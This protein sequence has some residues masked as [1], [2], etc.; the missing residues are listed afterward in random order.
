MTKAEWDQVNDLYIALLNKDNRTQFDEL[1]YRYLDKIITYVTVIREARNMGNK[2]PE[3]NF[4]IKNAKQQMDLAESKLRAYI[5]SRR[6]MSEE[7]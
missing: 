5:N 1:R 6:G 4:F 7:L 2:H 3:D